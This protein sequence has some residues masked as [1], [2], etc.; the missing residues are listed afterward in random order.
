MNGPINST[1]VVQGNMMSVMRIVCKGGDISLQTMYYV[2]N[3]CEFCL[4]VC[5]VI[6]LV[7]PVSLSNLAADVKAALCSFSV[8]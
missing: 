5:F 8:I 3:M 4:H 6:E 7:D 2:P 1:H